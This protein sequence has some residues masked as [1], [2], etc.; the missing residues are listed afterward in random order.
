MLNLTEHGQTTTD[1]PDLTEEVREAIAR[2]A[3][4]EEKMVQAA[5]KLIKRHTLYVELKNDLNLAMFVSEVC[6][7]AME[8]K[9]QAS[10]LEFE[11]N[12]A[13]QSIEN[14]LQRVFH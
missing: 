8:H 2:I 5:E 11:I 13:M 1:I 10:G 9:N 7:A 6:N 12:E 14:E 3:H 4:L